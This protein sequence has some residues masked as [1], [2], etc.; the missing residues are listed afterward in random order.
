MGLI[1]L[2]IGALFAPVSVSTVIAAAIVLVITFV[3]E[4]LSQGWN[5]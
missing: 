4:I 1:G 5:T 3:W 2:G